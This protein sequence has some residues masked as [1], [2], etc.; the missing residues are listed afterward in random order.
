MIINKEINPEREIYHLGALV[1][2]ILTENQNSKLDFMDVFQQLNK[3]IKVSVNLF[4]LVLDWLFIL[5]LVNK[6]KDAIIKCF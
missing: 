4:I 3:K 2:E 1:I 6:Q 5:G